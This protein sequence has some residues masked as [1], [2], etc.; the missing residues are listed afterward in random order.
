MER[1]FVDTSAWVAH[2]N[3]GDPDHAAVRDV[4]R[5]YRGRRVTSNFVFDE[6][7]TLCRYRLGYDVAL[8][9]GEALLEHEVCE[10]I[11]LTA[12]DESDAW[13]LFRDR[14]DQKCSFTDCTTFVLM[15]RLGLQTAAA[16]DQDFL[17]EGFVLLPS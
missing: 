1:L 14:A 4:L 6:T 12:R 10:I 7:V 16:L 11:R 13:D 15:R 5:R 2:A 9:V 8:T 17:R 3:R